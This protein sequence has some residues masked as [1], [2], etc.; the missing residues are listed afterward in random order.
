MGKANHR[1]G[2]GRRMDHAEDMHRVGKMPRVGAGA[3]WVR[4]EEA[5]GAN[6]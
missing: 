2:E 1:V 6:A 5:Q 3:G 4:G